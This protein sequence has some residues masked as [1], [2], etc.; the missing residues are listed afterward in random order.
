M[1]VIKPTITI[2]SNVNTAT[3]DPG[4]GSIALSLSAVDSLTSTAFET[5]IWN[6]DTTHSNCKINDNTAYGVTYMYA[7]N[8][9]SVDIWLT[10][11]DPS[12]SATNAAV[13]MILKAGEF[14]FFP[15][16]GNADLYAESASGS[17]NKLE[18]WIFKQ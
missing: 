9:S 8:T 3:T 16:G 12:N 17:N 13:L 14:A 5:V 6:V 15:W 2:V 4:P 7:K 18:T 10:S 1:A 11:G